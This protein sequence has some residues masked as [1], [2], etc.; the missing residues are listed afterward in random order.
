MSD[1]GE[2]LVWA[3]LARLH[4]RVSRHTQLSLLLLA[5]A[6]GSVALGLAEVVRGLDGG[7]ALGL[8]GAGML[9]G[10]LLACRA[11]PA[12]AGLG[13]AGVAG[14]AASLIGV[15]GLG[16]A[17]LGVAGSWQRP[18]AEHPLARYW[19]AL[20]TL[21]GRVQ[22]WLAALAAREPG[23]D[24]IVV[25]LLWSVALWGVAVW[26]GWCIARRERPLDAL[27]PAG[28]LLLLPLFLSG[29]TPIFLLPFLAATLALMVQVGH[30]AREARWERDGLDYSLELRPEIFLTAL[31]LTLLLTLLAALV[32]SLSVR[33]VAL[34]AQRL[35]TGRV[36]EVEPMSDSLGLDRPEPPRS[37]LAAWSS[38]RLP[39]SH[40]LG[41]GPELSDRVVMRIMVEG[42]NPSP[43][44][45]RWRGLT[46]DRYSG[47]GWSTSPTQA[48]FYKAGELAMEPTLPAQGSLRQHVTRA[49]EG[50][51]LYAAGE[52]RRVDAGVQRELAARRGQLRGC[53]RG[54]ELHR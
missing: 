8:A 35:V 49:A 5:S 16:R 31:Y 53:H 18:W 36:G 1:V 29:G 20:A 11:M 37:P 48:E 22:G 33:E 47:R 21:L 2:R 3:L 28:A 15:G 34:A 42:A 17:L 19:A 38:T 51:T 12:W 13:V 9:L 32:P 7:W 23:Y 45:Q 14:V 54:G 52:V 39:R 26:A 4:A 24:P 41:S 27:L 30:A 25:I 46:Y 50:V 43:L 44:A 6:L 10:W 40:L